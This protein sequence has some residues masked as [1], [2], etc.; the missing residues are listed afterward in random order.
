MPNLK[1]RRDQTPS[2]IQKAMRSAAQAEPQRCHAEDQHTVSA[3][4]TVPENSGV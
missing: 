4:P 3:K 1:K 2:T